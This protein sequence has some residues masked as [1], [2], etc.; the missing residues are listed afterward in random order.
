MNEL[1]K[2]PSFRDL[3]T[4]CTGRTI[5]IGQNLDLHLSFLTGT[6][7]YGP[8]TH[9][10]DI[11]FCVLAPF[12]D[13]LYGQLRSA[14][15]A[16]QHSLY[17]NSF[18]FDIYLGRVFSVNIIPMPGLDFM[19]WHKATQAMRLTPPISDKNYRC[20]V[21]Q[22]LVCAYRTALVRAD[23][24]DCVS[25]RCYIG[26]SPGITLDNLG[27]VIDKINNPKPIPF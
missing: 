4:H 1:T 3:I 5:P 10:S 22:Q 27:D 17:F 25:A 15:V 14:N 20:L 23:M 11:D 13:E 16:L 6:Q 19:A 7:V 12:H 18:K 26:Q 21:F 9:E 24:T 8:A 2:I